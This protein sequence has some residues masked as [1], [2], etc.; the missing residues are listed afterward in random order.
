[1]TNRYGLDPQAYESAVNAINAGMRQSIM[2]G[3]PPAS[4]RNFLV[5]LASDLAT[6]NPNFRADQFINMWSEEYAKQFTQGANEV[7][8]GSAAAS[9]AAG[10]NG[11]QMADLV[12]DQ[13]GFESGLNDTAPLSHNTQ[14]AQDNA[15][16]NML[17]TNDAVAQI[18]NSQYSEFAK[19]FLKNINTKELP[20]ETEDGAEEYV[21]E[22]RDQLTALETLQAELE[23][24]K[25]GEQ[26]TITPTT[27]DEVRSIVP[28]PLYGQL[29]N[30]LNDA[31]VSEYSQFETDTQGL[32]PEDSDDESRIMMI[33][34]EMRDIRR[35]TAKALNSSRAEVEK[36][37]EANPLAWRL[38]QEM[39]GT[40]AS[41]QIVAD[42]FVRQLSGNPS[43]ESNERSRAVTQSTADPLQL[44]SNIYRQVFDTRTMTPRVALASLQRLQTEV[45]VDPQAFGRNEHE[46]KGLEKEIESAAQSL[47]ERAVKEGL[48]EQQKEGEGKKGRG[49]PKKTYGAARWDAK[50]YYQVAEP[51]KTAQ[52]KDPPM[53]FTVGG[54]K[55]QNTKGKHAIT[56]T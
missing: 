4:F 26:S 41:P 45:R 28:P 12:R 36:A 8:A 46:V 5:N 21:N 23:K 22:V 17:P 40:T 10:I 32:D 35:E 16:R 44:I 29:L 33:A 20:T 31:K 3:I 50:D 11:Q 37:I 14:Q 52:H 30:R 18:I 56:I 49:R 34:N 42:G 2:Q 19:S 6:K 38:K 43:M 47:A 27:L 55:K 25:K 15:A 53:R 1:M 24:A 7:Q 9:S 39:N 13:E 54:D 48:M 51:A